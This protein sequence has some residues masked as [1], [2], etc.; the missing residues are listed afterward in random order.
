MTVAT[1]VSRVAYTGDG[2]NVA[3]AVPFPFFDPADVTVIERTI[4]SGAEVSKSLN[5]DYTVAG[6]GGSTGTVTASLAPPSSKQWV[7]LRATPLS[8]LIDYVSNDGFPAETHEAG[9]DRAAMRAQEIQEKLSRSLKFPPGDSSGIDPTLP[10]S[11]DRAGK[12]LG[13]DVTG[14]PVPVV[15]IPAGSVSLPLAIASGGTGTTTADGARAALGSAG[16]ADANVFGATQTVRSTD[17]GASGGPDLLLDR[18]STTPAASDVLGAV[19][20]QGRNAAGTPVFYAVEQAEIVDPGNGSEDGLWTVLTRVAG[21]LATRFKIGLGLFD[22]GATDG[23]KGAGTINVSGGYYLNGQL[24]T[25]VPAGT[26]VQRTHTALS[27]VVAV[28]EDIPVDDT[29]PQSGEGTPVLSHNHTPLAQNNLLLVRIVLQLSTAGGAPS[30]VVALFK[31]SEASA[32]AA[33]VVDGPSLTSVALEYQMP[34]PNTTT[35]AFKVRVGDGGGTVYVNGDSSGVRL[36]N[37]VSKSTITV[38]ELK[39]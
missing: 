29:A 10:S 15:D 8:Q 5:I 36:F 3:F 22:A 28:T 11:V 1:T 31:D 39:S 7:I 24:L 12:V 21:S 9:L 25:A 23:D 19:K 20:F 37:T 4:A 13:F 2:I 32:R 26:I 16:L 30:A 34:A 27:A 33:V 35:I 14:K 17:V 6:G 18:A 38:E